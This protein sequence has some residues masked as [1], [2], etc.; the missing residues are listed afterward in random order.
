MI[1]FSINDPIFERMKNDPAINLSA[2][3][4]INCHWNCHWGQHRIL[5]GERVSVIAGEEDVV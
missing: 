3:Q 1:M 5:F 2:L 4:K